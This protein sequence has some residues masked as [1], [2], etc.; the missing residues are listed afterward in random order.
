MITQTIEG[1]GCISHHEFD[2]Y[3]GRAQDVDDDHDT[4]VERFHE[5]V[6][7][8]QRH[9]VK[10]MMKQTVIGTMGRTQT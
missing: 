9:Q 4:F 1:R 10:G 2:I 6:I 3:L 5:D 8:Q 7:N